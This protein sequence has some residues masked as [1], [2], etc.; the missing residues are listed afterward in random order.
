MA[1][2]SKQKQDK[3]Q[4]KEHKVLTVDKIDKPQEVLEQN[5]NALTIVGGFDLLEMMIDGVQNVNPERKARKK[6]FL[7]ESNKKDER[8]ELKRKLEIWAEVLSSPG[9][10]SDMVEKCDEQAE[11]A[12][13]VLKSN[14]KETIN[15]V[16]DLE[17]SYRSVALFFKNTEMDKLKNVSFMNASSEQVKDLDNTRFF[18]KVYAE[19][20]ANYDRLDLIWVQIVWLRSGLNWLMRIRSCLLQILNTSTILMM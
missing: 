14:L 1:E 6:I 17:R 9:S 15:E 10:L 16:K 7:S 11:I 3:E 8:E 19:L 18:D 20:K 13:A 4:F 12:E 2:E 5:I